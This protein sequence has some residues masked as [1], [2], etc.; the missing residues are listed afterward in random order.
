MAF[1][2]HDGFKGFKPRNWPAF[3]RD[4]IE[5][6]LTGRIDQIMNSPSINQAIV[7]SWLEIAAGAV[8]DLFCD[9]DR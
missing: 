1:A 4:L 7:A 9:T 3:D 8:V 6:E 2:A 5:K